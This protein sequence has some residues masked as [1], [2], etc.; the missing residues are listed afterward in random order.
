MIMGCSAF[1][2]ES[3]S[4]F[5]RI[6]LPPTDHGRWHLSQSQWLILIA[7]VLLVPPLTSLGIL[8]M[9]DVN[10]LINPA[11]I[12]AGTTG[13]SCWLFNGVAFGVAIWQ[14]G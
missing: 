7:I 13:F 12:T 3:G 10:T 11:I 4:W 6:D 1:F 2:Q 8:S 14:W 9:A 5:A